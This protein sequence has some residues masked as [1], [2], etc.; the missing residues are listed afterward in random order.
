[1][2]DSVIVL[3]FV[4]RYFVSIMGGNHLDGEERREVVDLFYLS[5]WCLV[6]VLWLV[7]AMPRVCLQ[8]VIVV[9]PDHT[10]LIFFINTD[11]YSQYMRFPTMWYVRP[12]KPQISLRICAV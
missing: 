12:A 11:Y 5:S 1:M 8:F 6:M 4:L 10:H 7:L 2:W 9:F 3:Y